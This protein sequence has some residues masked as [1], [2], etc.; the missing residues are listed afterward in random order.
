MISKTRVPGHYLR[1]TQIESAGVRPTQ[2]YISYNS[3][4]FPVLYSVAPIQDPVGTESLISRLPLSRKWQPTPVSL[5]GK[6]HGQRSLVGCSP[7]GR[8]E[9][10]TTERRTPTPKHPYD[11]AMPLRVSSTAG[12]F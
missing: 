3:A 8:K 2:A 9:S 11:Q 1:L 10:G 12:R 6:S 7:W 4:C 5:P